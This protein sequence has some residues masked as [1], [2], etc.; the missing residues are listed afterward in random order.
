MLLWLLFL[1]GVL[2]IVIILTFV[3]AALFGRGEALPPLPPANEIKS[4]NRAA[5][6]R[7]DFDALRFEVVPR[8]YRQDQVDEVIAYLLKQQGIKGLDLEETN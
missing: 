8:G 1:V 3:F 5:I 4:H 7:G 6:D 2:A